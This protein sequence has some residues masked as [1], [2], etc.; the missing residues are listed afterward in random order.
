MLRSRSYIAL[1]MA[2]PIVLGASVSVAVAGGVG[3][4]NEKRSR[5]DHAT[6][7]WPTAE[8]ATSSV[9]WRLMPGGFFREAT[10]GAVAV[11]LSADL[12]GAPVHFRVLVNGQPLPQGVAHFAPSSGDT[13]RSYT[14]V[15]P[16]SDGTCQAFQVK[17][18]S[19]T[20]KRVELRHATT[21]AT[22]NAPSPAVPCPEAP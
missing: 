8:Y 3:S 11:T 9:H 13:S 16:K 18:R 12:R 10:V 5:V 22:Y 7:V 6:M 19:P 14:W 2:I 21:V 4:F 20:G 1:F 15:L 17:W